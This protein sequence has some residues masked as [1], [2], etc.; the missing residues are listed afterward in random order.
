[1]VCRPTTK[2]HPMALVRHHTCRALLIVDKGGGDGKYGRQSVVP[3][4][5]TR[6][7]R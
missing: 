6:N 7:Y 2:G 1:M 3:C 5:G 4:S